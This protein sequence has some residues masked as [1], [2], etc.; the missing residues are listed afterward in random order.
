[1]KQIS[2]VLILGLLCLNEVSASQCKPLILS[3]A[4]ADSGC[5]FES[6]SIGTL[7][8]NVIYHL[9]WPDIFDAYL[10][11]VVGIGQCQD[12]PVCCSQNYARIECWPLFD[13]PVATTGGS[14][15]Q[16]VRHR[17]VRTVSTT[18]SAGCASPIN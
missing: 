6:G 8:K 17:G 13:T 5:D 9:Q 18:C 16:R 4:E 7:S 1:M 15:S 2:C 10:N 14:F 11:D 12:S 3:S